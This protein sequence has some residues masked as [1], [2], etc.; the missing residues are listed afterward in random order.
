MATHYEVLGIDRSA[1]H[2]E[3][4]KAYFRRTSGSRKAGFIRGSSQGRAERHAI[5]EAYEVLID[6]AKRTAYDR[7]LDPGTR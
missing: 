3:V 2:E 4:A 6:R 1:T 7:T 5:E